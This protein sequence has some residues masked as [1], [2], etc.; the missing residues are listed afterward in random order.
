MRLHA[1]RLGAYPD[2]LARFDAASRPDPFTGG[3]MTYVHR[4]DGSARLEVV[5]GGA[6]WNRANPGVH[7]PGPFIW[8][9]P[10]PR[11]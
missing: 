1:L 5:G 8:E 4:G 11:R 7:N 10:P 6:L 2:C 3:K 9:L